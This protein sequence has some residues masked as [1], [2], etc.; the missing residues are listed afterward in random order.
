MG[1][2]GITVQKEGIGHPGALKIDGGTV[3]A[4]GQSLSGV[5]MF[6]G[7]VTVESG[8]SLTAVGAELGINGAVPVSY[9]HLDVYKRQSY[10][11]G[12][13]RVRMVTYSA[14]VTGSP[15]R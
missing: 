11:P 10:V 4:V 2:L 13:N 3:I 6:G 14:L 15:G 1:E 7:M 12:S 8:A 5:Y 9:T